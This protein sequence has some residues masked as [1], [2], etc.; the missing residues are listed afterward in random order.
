MNTTK[1]PFRVICPANGR[2][3]PFTLTICFLFVFFLKG[4]LLPA[5]AEFLFLPGKNLMKPGILLFG[6][7]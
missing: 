4:A 2:V 1:W 6:G 5:D 3:T 7:P